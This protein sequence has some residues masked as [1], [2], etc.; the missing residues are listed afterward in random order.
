MMDD[1]LNKLREI[2]TRENIILKPNPYLKDTFVDEYGEEH[3]LVL[4]NYQKQ[5]LLSALMMER[6][7]DLNDTGLGKTL[8]ELAVISCVL[9]KES[10]YVPIVIATKSALFQ[11]RNESN[12]FMKNMEVV[13]I[14]GEPH[15]RQAGYEE[16]FWRHNPDKK[17]ILLLTYDNILRDMDRSVIRDR[18]YKPT[19]EEKKALKEAKVALKEATTLFEAEKD[20]F[21]KHFVERIYDVHEYVKKSIDVLDLHGTLSD[22]PKP[23][24]WSSLDQN[25]LDLFAQSRLFLKSK[26]SDV[27]SANNVVS[28]P[29]MVPGLTDYLADLQKDHP[30]A[31]YMLIL[32]EIHKLKNHKSQFHQKVFDLA[33]ICPRI[34]GM[35][36]TPV[37]NRL[38]EFW[39]ILRIIRPTLFPKITHFMATYCITRMQPIGG[40]RQVPIVVGYKNLEHF[41]AQIEPY[42]LGRKKHEVAKELPEL[43]SQEIECDLS[44]VQEE[45]YDMA[46]LGMDEKLDDADANGGEMLAGLTMMQQAVDAPQLIANEE[47]TPFEGKSG[48]IEALLDLLENEAGQKIIIFSKF[49]KMI[50]LV[51]REIKQAKYMGEDGAEHK[52]Y[53]YVRITGKENNPKVREQNKQLFQD[54]KSGINIILITTAGSESLNLQMASHFCFLDLPFSYG[55]YIQLTGRYIRI[56]SKY[57]TVVAHHFLGMRRNGDQTIDHHVLKALR[58]KK[59][60]ADKVAGDSLPG[61]F[62]FTTGDAVNDVIEILRKS[63]EGRDGARP[64]TKSK[65]ARPKSSEMDTLD[66]PITLNQPDFSDI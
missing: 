33:K 63:K 4:R 34:I 62:K 50:S 28:P 31:K 35:T 16:F 38:M 29:K 27:E 60:L 21:D 25:R 1:M 58:S 24:G 45:L 18:S 42:C 8:I 20:I 32:D 14:S 55:D 12:K 7:L 23:P 47:G 19:K 56:G 22:A 65:S 15:E 37:K 5:S 57:L 46:E 9:T 3:P 44:D 43:I 30:E 26:K 59:K 51:E 13:T 17:R 11:W 54:P 66:P 40:G 2:R 10:E 49:E 39:S 41:V 53:K 36:A 64:K 48:K 61:A 52:G 6:S